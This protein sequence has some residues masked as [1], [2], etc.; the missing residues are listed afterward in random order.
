MTWRS[1]ICFSLLG[2]SL[3]LDRTPLQAA[4]VSGRVELRDS[5][6]A[7][8]RKKKDY[9]GV[10]LWLDAVEAAS[11]AAPAN[12]LPARMVQKDKT[13]TPHLL[14]I[15]T[16]TAV[17]FPN[18]D[19][20]FHNAFSNYDGKTFNVGLYP[21]GSSR[22]VRF[23]R[24]GVV[25]VFCNIHASMSA[26][27]VVLN[28]PYFTMSHKDGSFEIPAVPAGDYRLRLFHERATPATLDELER[29]VTVGDSPLVLAP[30]PVSESG[31]LPVPH[32]DKF[33]HAYHPAPDDGGTYPAVRK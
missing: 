11:A 7:Q 24:P 20:I 18:F 31:Y 9:S 8:V 13:F 17:D 19:P 3:L 2:L 10:V 21:P 15:R 26:V 22:S 4:A 1:L 29:R 30:L 16:G 23:N 32:T 28:T 5:K 12:L 33:G 6:D 27:I 25:R 14:A